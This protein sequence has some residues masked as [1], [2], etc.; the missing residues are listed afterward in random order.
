MTPAIRRELLEFVY[1]A[2]YERFARAE[3][4]EAVERA[5]E[6]LILSNPQAGA[7]VR[8]LGGTRKVRMALPGGGK[9]G[10]ARFLYF[11]RLARGR[12][13]VLTAY[14]KNVQADLSSEQRK[15]IRQL[16]SELG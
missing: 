12:V 16:I 2:P 4:P 7:V 5:F 8:G 3:I 13:Y 1:L 9:R 10:G 6:S 15:R 14:A 11:V